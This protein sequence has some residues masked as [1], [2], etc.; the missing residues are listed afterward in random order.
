MTEMTDRAAEMVLSLDADALWHAG[1]DA[2]E[3]YPVGDDYDHVNRLT[4]G[5]LIVSARSRSHVAVYLQPQGT[6]TA[7]GQAHGP[8]AVDIGKIDPEPETGEKK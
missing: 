7:V 6:I 1:N 3:G 8:W 5:H 4:I 2:G